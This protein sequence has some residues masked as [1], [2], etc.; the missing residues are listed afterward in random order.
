[1]K[2]PKTIS[3]YCPFC[4]KKTQQE[5]VIV[6]KG[7]PSGLSLGSRK[8]KKHKRGI[9]GHGKYSKRPASEIKRAS[10]TVKKQDIRYK[11]KQCKKMTVQK[12][13]KRAKK[14]ELVK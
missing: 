13:G 14:F 8:K 3:R 1:M 12:K 11:C 9:G 10:K 7:K 4:N 6:K 2:L 5:I